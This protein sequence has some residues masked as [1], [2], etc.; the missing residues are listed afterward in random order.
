MTSIF[1]VE[2]LE[3][4]I[5][6]WLWSLFRNFQERCYPFGVGYKAFDLGVT[7]GLLDHVLRLLGEGVVCTL[8]P[9]GSIY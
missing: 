5:S 3:M 9:P 4:S 7:I 2:A 8:E 1:L 6:I